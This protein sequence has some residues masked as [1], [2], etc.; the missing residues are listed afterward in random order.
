[1]KGEN[2]QSEKGEAKTE[3]QDHKIGS[4]HAENHSFRLPPEKDICDHSN[5]RKLG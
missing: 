3:G 5:T 2:K 1:M 4:K